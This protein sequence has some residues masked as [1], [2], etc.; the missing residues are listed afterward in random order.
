MRYNWTKTQLAGVKVHAA[1]CAVL[2]H[3]QRHHAPELK[4]TDDSD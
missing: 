1:V 3:V 2:R 4:V